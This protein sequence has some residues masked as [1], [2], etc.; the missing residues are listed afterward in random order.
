MATTKTA[1]VKAAP[2]TVKAS[3]AN[4][5]VVS[6]PAPVAVK[7]DPIKHIEKHLKEFEP[8]ELSEGLGFNAIKVYN[9][10][11]EWAKSKPLIKHLGKDLK[12]KLKDQFD[13]LV[14]MLDSINPNGA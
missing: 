2:I 5:T 4:K 8:L 7:A 13:K 11:N 6:K 9:I 14:S 12:G 1:V 10:H 3:E